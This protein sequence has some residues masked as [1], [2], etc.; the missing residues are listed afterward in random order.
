MTDYSKTKTAVHQSQRS[1]VVAL[2]WQLV[3]V[4][5]DNTVG[6]AGKCEC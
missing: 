3:E 1:F 6:N 2:A 4:F 5:V